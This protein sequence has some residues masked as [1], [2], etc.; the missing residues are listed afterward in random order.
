MKGEFRNNGTEYH[1]V[2]ATD[3]TEPI[4][5]VKSPKGTFY[6]KDTPQKVKDILDRF[7]H[8]SERL[9]LDTGDT[10]TGQSWGE[11]YDI[12]GTLGRTMGPLKSPIL[13]ANSRSH[14]GGIILDHCIVRI[15]FT[16]KNGL[17]LYKHPNYQPPKVE[18]P[19]QAQLYSD[20]LAG[21]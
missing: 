5:Y 10:T 17:E 21:I 19:K 2:S 7:M 3:P 16:G 11:C 4:V 14:G 15:K 12:Q 6:H 20:V 9:F 8:S 18:F 1:T 13:L